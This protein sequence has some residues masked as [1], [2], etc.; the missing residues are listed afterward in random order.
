MF[1]DDATCLAVKSADHVQCTDRPA[2]CT[3]LLVTIFGPPLAL[4]VETNVLPRGA[5]TGACT[6]QCDEKLVREVR[7]GCWARVEEVSSAPAHKVS[8]GSAC[9][10]E[11]SL[12]CGHGVCR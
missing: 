12:L 9:D 4:T 1:L 10:V 7:V 11:N 5:Q 6:Q 2:P 3:R 8:L